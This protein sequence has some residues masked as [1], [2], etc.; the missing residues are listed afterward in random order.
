ME[1]QGL[2]SCQGLRCVHEIVY[3][4]MHAHSATYTCITGAKCTAAFRI[5]AVLRVSLTDQQWYS[6]AGLAALEG[7]QDVS[8]LPQPQ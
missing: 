4:K 1:V 6:K 2:W 7:M 8:E 3:H 5:I